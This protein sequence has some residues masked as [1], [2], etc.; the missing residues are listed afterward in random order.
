MTK[1]VLIGIFR[2][3]TNAEYLTPQES[4][5]SNSCSSRHRASKPCNCG[6]CGYLL[7]F[8]CAH[9]S[10]YGCNS[11]PPLADS[12]AMKLLVA[13]DV[14]GNITALFK[15]VDAVNKKAGVC[16]SWHLLLHPTTTQAHLR[17]CYVSVL[18]SGQAIQ[19][20]RTTRRAG[21]LSPGPWR[22][23]FLF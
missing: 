23:C 20:G 11:R 1:S 7:R 12:M 10:S 9:H 5:R 3:Y 2:T 4:W 17:C 15:R 21:N 22:L 19:V 16:P 6:L 18:S 8:L 14:E 13:G